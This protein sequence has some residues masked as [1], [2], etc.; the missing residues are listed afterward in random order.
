MADATIIMAGGS[1]TRLWPASIPARPKQ[2]MRLAGGV[3]LVQQAMVRAL[4]ATPDG[5]VVIVTHRDHVEGIAEHA[6]ELAAGI[7]PGGE[8]VDGLLERLVYLPEPM[9]RNTTPAIALGVRYLHETL[10]A[11]ASVLVLTADHVIRPVDRFAA[12]AGL[13]AELAGEGYLV[14]F[15]IVPTH[16]ETGYGYIQAGSQLGA[17]LVVE[18]F[19]EKPDLETA[20]DYL[21]SGNFYWNSG[22][23]CFTTGR[24]QAELGEYQP[25]I[26]L[27]FQAAVEKLSVSPRP[28]GSAGADAESLRP[29]YERLPKISIDYALMEQSKRVAV[30]P[31]SF[32]WNDVG[33]WD[34]ASKLAPSPDPATPPQSPSLVQVEAE[35][36][37]V[38]SELPVA[39]CGVSDLH[40]VVRNGK[41]LVCKRGESQL[42]KQAVEEA[43]RCGLHD[44]FSDPETGDQ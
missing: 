37:H 40:V 17:G 35:R 43:Q 31:A 26:S 44:F 16:P 10:G 27:A 22:M 38:D 5:P 1:G 15:G 14:C 33:S 6:R 2:L 7:V 20:H 34:E 9:G 21:R 23:F 11:D 3:S 28:D 30:V 39:I 42:V 25:E 32:S 19:R 18:A 13:A 36:N 4:A 29:L 41:V 12:D 24:F 8:K